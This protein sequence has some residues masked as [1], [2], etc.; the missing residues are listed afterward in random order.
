MELLLSEYY[1]LKFRSRGIFVNVTNGNINSGPFY[2]DKGARCTRG[3]RKLLKNRNFSL[4]LI[5]GYYVVRSRNI[6]SNGLL[7]KRI[8]RKG[9]KWRSRRSFNQRLSTSITSL[10]PLPSC[11]EENPRLFSSAR[12]LRLSNDVFSI[13]YRLYF[14]WQNISSKRRERAFSD[15]N[16]RI[17]KRSG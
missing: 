15:V 11:H 7:F 4:D 2:L 5:R 6:L 10:T 16:G 17:W 12:K 14:S 8:E 3:V 9:R 13:I 1:I